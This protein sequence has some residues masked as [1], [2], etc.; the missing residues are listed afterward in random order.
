MSLLL[1]TRIRSGDLLDH[2]RLEELVA[3]GGMASVFRATDTRTGHAVAVKIPHPDKA[4]DRLVLDRFYYETEIG[5]KFDHPGLVKV[6]PNDGASHRYVVMEWI[7]GQPLRQIIDEREGLSIERAVQITLKICEVLEHIHEQGIVHLDLKPDNI[8]VTSNDGIKLIDFDIA[9]ETKRGFLALLRPRR[10]GTPDYASPEQI[11]GKSGDARSDIYSLG[12]ILYEMLTGEVPFSGVAP[13]TALNLRLA[14]DPMPPCEVN[15]E[16][17]AQLQDIVCR[18][19]ARVPAKR[20]RTV[21]ELRS[22]LEQISQR[23]GYEL[24]G[25]QQ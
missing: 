24:V 19:I 9:R 8:I 18:A 1:T 25:S 7:E 11:R 3:T 5:R 21:R 6:L 12:L 22:Q 13:L 16:I 2:Y 4:N 20:H 15:S 17:P 14:R 10:M 23:G